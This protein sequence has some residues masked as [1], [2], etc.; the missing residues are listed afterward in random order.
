MKKFPLAQFPFFHQAG[1][2]MPTS[3][4]DLGEVE[5]RLARTTFWNFSLR[6]V[7]PVP[8]HNSSSASLRQ[9]SG[10]YVSVRLQTI[11]ISANF[12]WSSKVTRGIKESKTTQIHMNIVTSYKI[13][14]CILFYLTE[15]QSRQLR[16]PEWRQER[17]KETI[18]ITNQ[19]WVIHVVSEGPSNSR[20]PSQGS[21]PPASMPLPSERAHKWHLKIPQEPLLTLIS[22]SCFY[23]TAIM[24]W[25]LAPRLP[26]MVSCQIPLSPS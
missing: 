18:P 4:G 19:T 25:V 17:W 1:G 2:T 26:Y 9:S 13:F 10:S 7:G 14:L 3:P 6:S 23:H 15:E 20:W 16:Q 12:T 21:T 8:M 11:L 22:P 5:G 24:S